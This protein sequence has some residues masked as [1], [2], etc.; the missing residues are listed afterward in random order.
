[1]PGTAWASHDADPPGSP[2]SGRMLRCVGRIAQTCR[3][4]YTLTMAPRDPADIVNTRLREIC[5]SGGWWK[6][7]ERVLGDE[8]TKKRP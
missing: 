5:A 3:A 1:M 8:Y 2:A 7:Y 6:E 4:Q